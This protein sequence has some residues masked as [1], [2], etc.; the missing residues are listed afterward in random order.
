MKTLAQLLIFI[1]MI[2]LGSCRD[3]F[4]GEPLSIINNSDYRIYYWY[5]YWKTEGYINYHYPDTIL[6]IEKPVYLNTIAP[7]NA[8]G[9][10]EAD[11]DWR[12]IFSELPEG[13]FSFY[14]FKESPETQEDWDLIRQTYNLYRKDVTYQELVDNH[15][16]IN[17]P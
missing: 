8:T 2:H 3:K 14:F 15:Y 13:K 5:S 12:K 17:Y 7:H 9:V 4:I 1:S 16:K 11:P 10:G 6:P